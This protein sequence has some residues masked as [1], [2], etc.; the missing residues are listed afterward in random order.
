MDSQIAEHAAEV[1]KAVAH[2]IRLQIIEVLEHQE[3]CVGEMMEA[4][5]LQQAVLSQQLRIMRDKGVLST[6]REGTKVYYH[7]DNHNV[8]K[9]LH[10]M[11]DHCQAPTNQ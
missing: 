11:Y 5:G 4:L 7:V 10:C 8:I 1:L 6:R 2:P 9:L 3:H